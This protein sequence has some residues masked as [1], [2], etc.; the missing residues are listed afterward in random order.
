MGWAAEV[1]FWPVAK[2][3]VPDERPA[4]FGVGNPPRIGWAQS[5][6][7]LVGEPVD[8]DWESFGN[9]DDDALIW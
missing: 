3:L 6:S 7:A 5:A 2:A 4:D 1:K 8:T 9:E